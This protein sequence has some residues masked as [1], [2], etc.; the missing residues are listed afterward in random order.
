MTQNH[1]TLDQT[2]ILPTGGDISFEFA[3]AAGF[4][5][6]SRI[7]RH[8][9]HRSIKGAAEAIRDDDRPEAKRFK[10]FSSMN[11]VFSS[12][13]PSVTCTDLAL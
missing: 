12:V 13:R 8:K 2:M 3:G 6:A 7:N 11:N 5:G 1:A 9:R 10:R 4:G